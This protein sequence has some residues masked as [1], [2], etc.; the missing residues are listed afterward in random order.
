VSLSVSGDGQK[1]VLVQLPRAANQ[2]NS[3]SSASAAATPSGGNSSFAIDAASAVG[4]S[5]ALIGILAQFSG[6]SGSGSNGQAGP[7]PGTSSASDAASSSDSPGVAGL[8]ATL[9]ADLAHITNAFQLESSASAGSSSGSQADVSG[10]SGGTSS[11]GAGDTTS[12]T[13]GFGLQN[14]FSVL[15]A[16]ASHGSSDA[17]NDGSAT[18]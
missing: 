7:P 16:Y 8:L 14:F 3:A 17:T 12:S 15:E 10:G 18:A 9:N 1:S 5:P 2:Q 4:L 11:A 6:G 13:N